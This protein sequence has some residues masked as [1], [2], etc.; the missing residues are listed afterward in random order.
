MK[1]VFD[2][3]NVLVKSSFKTIAENL[4]IDYF[5]RDEQYFEF[6]KGKLTAIQYYNYVL[7]KYQ[8]N[9]SYSDFC[10]AWNSF[11]SEEVDGMYELIKEL[12]KT[13]ELYVLSN[14]NVLHGLYVQRRYSHLFNQFS[15]IL[16]SFCL[17]CRKPESEIFE[18][19]LKATNAKGEDIIFIDDK[20]ENI[21]A[22]EH[23]SIKTILFSDAVNLEKS[24]LQ[25]SFNNTN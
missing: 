17:G 25:L 16:Y 9:I 18:E 1:I 12:S 5:E 6:S 4:G 3:G 13:N 24:I 8:L 14:S 15:Q 19:L 7:Q 21:G 20:K 11:Y 22:A 2:I 10:T 23:F